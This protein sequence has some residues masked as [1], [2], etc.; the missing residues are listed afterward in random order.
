MR[1]LRAARVQL[2]GDAEIL[3]AGLLGDGLPAGDAREVDEGGLDDAR[4]AFDRLDEAL[5]EAVGR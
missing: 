5:G 4:L 2:H 3:A 1:L